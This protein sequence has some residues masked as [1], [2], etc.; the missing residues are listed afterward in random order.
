MVACGNRAG[1]RSESED[2]YRIGTALVTWV[3]VDAIAGLL[4]AVPAGYVVLNAIHAHW[5]EDQAKRPENKARMEW[6]YQQARSKHIQASLYK[7]LPL[8]SL[9]LG[10]GL[11]IVIGA[12]NLIR[13]WP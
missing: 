7:K 12:R 10:V 9:A 1:S 5:L 11:E 3:F 13:D 2:Y 6:L 4:L 8:A